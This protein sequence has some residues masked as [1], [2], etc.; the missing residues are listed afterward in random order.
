V[1]TFK[2]NKL[3]RDGPFEN[4]IALGQS[5]KYKVLKKPEL[6][7]ALHGKLQEELSEFD[8]NDKNSLAELADLQEVIDSLAH[9][10]GSSPGKLR[11]LQNA[12]RV[13]KGTFDKRIFV[14]TVTL[15]DDDPWVEYYANYPDRFQ[16]V[17]Q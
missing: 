13:K 1:R 10:L 2:L 16:E 6:I 17:K 12:V 11:T 7:K 14:E 15:A 9:L 5:V 3:V 8:P 4:M